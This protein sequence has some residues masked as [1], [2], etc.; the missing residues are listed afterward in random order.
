M[1]TKDD[2]KA[3]ET[4]MATKEDLQRFAIKE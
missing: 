1:A 4:R 3:L 2:I